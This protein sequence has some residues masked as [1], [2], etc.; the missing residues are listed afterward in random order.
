[1][2]P[3]AVNGLLDRHMEELMPVFRELIAA[4]AE[5]VGEVSDM[6]LE[7][8]VT[9]ML[10]G[11]AELLTEQLP[12]PAELGIGTV[13]IVPPVLSAGSLAEFG[14][15]FLEYWDSVWVLDGEALDRLSQLEFQRS[16]LSAIAM[17]GLVMLQNSRGLHLLCLLV[18]A[19]SLL[20]LVLRLG[21]GFRCFSWLAVVY[22][23]AGAMDAGIALMV[24]LRLPLMVS[25]EALKPVMDTVMQLVNR[26]L[27]AGATILGLC[28]LFAIVASVGN[29]L[30]K[31]K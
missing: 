16:D 21:N 7:F 4:D 6:E 24:K 25:T 14:R 3:E 13:T 11:C 8:V 23:I 15:D 2:T 22:F 1:M 30:I 9:A 10:Y 27:A 31:R 29:K 12:T 20:V 17:Q 26:F 28:V 18:L 5:S 19:L